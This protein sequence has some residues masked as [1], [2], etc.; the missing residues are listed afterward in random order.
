LAERDNLV[1]CLIRQDS[2]PQ[3]VPIA[4]R[5]QDA[6]KSECRVVMM[7]IGLRALTRVQASMKMRPRPAGLNR[8]RMC[9]IDYMKE[10][11]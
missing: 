1:P 5:E 9:R 6:G 2:K 11:K 7:R 8:E 4:V 10:S 3:G